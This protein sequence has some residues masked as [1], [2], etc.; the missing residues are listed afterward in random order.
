[1]NERSTDAKSSGADRRQF[2]RFPVREKLIG[3]LVDADLPVRIRDISFGGFATETLEPL[4][5]GAVHRV[6]FTSEDDRQE[7]LPAQSVHS[8]PSCT[9][10]GTPCYVTGF[11]FVGAD[12]GDRQR[13]RQLI[14]AVTSEGLYRDVS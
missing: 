6:R 13:V 9:S 11:S 10:D 7:V 14:E 4:S 12:S 1:M 3:H 8:W 2:P 5:I